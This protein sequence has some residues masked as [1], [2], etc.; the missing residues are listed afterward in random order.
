M[1]ERALREAPLARWALIVPLVV[2][3]RRGWRDAFAR[4]NELVRGQ[5][6]RVLVLVVVANLLTGVVSFGIGSVFSFL[7][8]FAAT[9]IGGT[10]AGALTVPDPA[11]GHEL[12]IVLWQTEAQ[13]RRA[14]TDYSAAF[15][16]GRRRLVAASP[17][18][19]H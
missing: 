8:T 19:R 4:S 7:P 5:T 13:A 2:I 1:S 17:R 16:T 12:T 14:L 15:R 18:Q 3:E 11:G 9:W 6:G 10:V